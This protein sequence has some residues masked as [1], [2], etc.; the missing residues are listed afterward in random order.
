[1]LFS[2][3]EQ[4]NEFID[5]QRIQIIHM[6]NKYLSADTTDATRPSLKIHILCGEGRLFTAFRQE[7]ALA[8]LLIQ[9]FQR[10]SMLTDPEHNA[11]KH[12]NALF[13]EAVGDDLFKLYDA[14]NLLGARNI[15][16]EQKIATDQSLKLSARDLQYWYRTRNGPC[17]LSYFLGHKER[18]SVSVTNT[19]SFYQQHIARLLRKE[20]HP[21]LAGTVIYLYY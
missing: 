14:I 6:L 19:G 16:D 11:L 10:F 18:L 9:P 4:S 17:T 5:A 13:F 7:T 8:H 12:G 20:W 1:M 2:I 15:P 3:Q 21:Y